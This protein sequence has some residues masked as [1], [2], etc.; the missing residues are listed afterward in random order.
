MRSASLRATC[1]AIQR[2]AR[3]EATAAR[4]RAKA[5]RTARGEQGTIVVGFTSSAPFHPFVPGVIRRFR[6]AYPRVTLR[7]EEHG[8]GE[9][10]DGL[11]AEE[12]DVAFVR[13]TVAD[14]EGLALHPLFEIVRLGFEP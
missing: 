9:L 5:G 8:T 12:I 14:R 4:A 3:A 11:R 10:I 13:S 6:E 7:L 1:G 2:R